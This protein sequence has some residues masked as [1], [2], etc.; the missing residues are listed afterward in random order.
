MPIISENG[1]ENLINGDRASQVS[2]ADN[3]RDS[4]TGEESP[5]EKTYDS[6]SVRESRRSK[7]GNGQDLIRRNGETEARNRPV[8]HNPEVSQARKDSSGFKLLEAA[9]GKAKRGPSYSASNLIEGVIADRRIGVYIPFWTID[10]EIED[11]V[12]ANMSDRFSSALTTRMI[13]KGREYA[14]GAAESIPG[15]G[16]YIS[17][18]AESDGAGLYKKYEGVTAKTLN[19]PMTW[20]ADPNAPDGGITEQEIRGMISFLQSGCYL[21]GDSNGGIGS[22]SPHTFHLKFGGLY[23]IKCILLSVATTFAGPWRNESGM[24]LLYKVELSVEQH[25]KLTAEDVREGGKSFIQTFDR[26]TEVSPKTSE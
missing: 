18:A 23:S 5:Q 6:Q 3:R 14:S 22:F 15:V 11:T 13:D 16:G 26:E 12:A 7:A 19:I 24:P 25:G 9:W 21:D 2:E 1:H 10:G 8:K 4:Y 20:V 17:D